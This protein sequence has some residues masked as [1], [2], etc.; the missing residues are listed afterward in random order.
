MKLKKESLSKKASRRKTDVRLHQ[1]PLAEIS[2][3]AERSGDQ[4]RR[5]PEPSDGQT[6]WTTN[7]RRKRRW[8]KKRRRRIRRHSKKDASEQKAVKE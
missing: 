4:A 3:S 6:V 7:E 5:S 2:L 8:K 1:D